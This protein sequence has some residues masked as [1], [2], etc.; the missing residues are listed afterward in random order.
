M[1]VRLYLTVQVSGDARRH[2]M[3]IFVDVGA[4]TSRS[5][6]TTSRSRRGVRSWVE[7]STWQKDEHPT[8]G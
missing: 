2:G 5:H 1:W 3:V 8:P 7:S 6:G 4:Q